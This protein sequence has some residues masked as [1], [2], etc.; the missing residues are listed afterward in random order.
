MGTLD[1][2]FFN[3]RREQTSK[4]MEAL[5][6]AAIPLMTSLQSVKYDGTDVELLESVA[7]SKQLSY[8]PCMSVVLINN[9]HS[10]IP[11]I[12][13]DFL[14]IA[15]LSILGPWYLDFT[16]T[17]ISN[18]T[19]LASVGL[20]SHSYS[21][22]PASTAILE[23]PKGMYRCIT[24]LLLCGKWA[25]RR[26]NVPI[27]VP[28]LRQLRSLELCIEF[29]ASEFWAALQAEQIWLRSLFLRIRLGFVEE[30]RKGME[31]TFT[32]SPKAVVKGNLA[33]QPVT[34]SI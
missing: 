23:H 30:T 20:Y 32:S 4:K 25:L 2:F 14:H 27:L 9:R 33:W 31:R 18:N 1:R 21:S 16:A 3:K 15:E 17:L 11:R 7:L 12:N 26:S 34:V 13:L 6:A 29:A 22:D 10:A 5:L 8:I 19:R 28:K 24:N